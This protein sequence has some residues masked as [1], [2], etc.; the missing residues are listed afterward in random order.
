MSK[1]ALP[2]LKRANDGLKFWNLAPNFP[3]VFYNLKY[4]ICQNFVR[5]E[6]ID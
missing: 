4:D 6:E 1:F 3:V 2:G 5:S